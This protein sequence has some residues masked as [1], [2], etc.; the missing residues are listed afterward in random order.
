MLVP[1]KGEEE[2]EAKV[3]HSPL[4]TQIVLK[5]TRCLCRCKKSA[6]FSPPC[7]TAR[8][9]RKALKD[10]YC[11]QDEEGD[12]ASSAGEGAGIAAQLSAAAVTTVA[13]TSVRQMIP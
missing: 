7:N 4:K 1:Q 3:K 5:G 6:P 2:S 10:K 9:L 13:V 12:A 11:P 8:E